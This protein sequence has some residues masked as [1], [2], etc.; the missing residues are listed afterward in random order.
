MPITIY[1]FTDKI[2]LE[3]ISLLCLRAV[4]SQ[5]NYYISNIVI[6]YYVSTTNLR[7]ECT[8]LGHFD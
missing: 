6:F 2:L 3:M 5:W 4:I 8:N 7:K 1:I